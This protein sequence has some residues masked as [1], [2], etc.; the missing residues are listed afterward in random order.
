[1]TTDTPIA[2]AAAEPPLILTIDIGSSSARVVVY[3]RHGRAVEGI[4]AQE[5]YTLR[6]A[7]NG[8]TEDDPDVALERAAR[9]VDAVLHLA[10]PLV[11]QIGAV[12]V[13]TLVS[14][15]L[16]VDAAGGPLTP[17]ISYAD[18]RNDAD[19]DA[20]RST[21]DEHAVHDRTDCLI[22]TSYCPARLA[23][24]RRV[25]TEVWRTAARF[26]TLGEYLEARR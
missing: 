11:V 15:I 25:Q 8:T 18:T 14:T 16:A 1:M 10:G 19:A 2:V 6:T 13:D 3:D 5:R 21:L 24:L 20:L 22:R 12:A 9:C 23:W 17:L 26:V 4:I 7:T